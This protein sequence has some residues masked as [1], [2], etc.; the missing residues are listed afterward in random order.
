MVR[1]SRRSSAMVVK[2]EIEEQ[3]TPIYGSAK[4]MVG[5]RQ[6]DEDQSAPAR[7]DVVAMNA[8]ILVRI[9]S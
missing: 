8:T 5:R 6:G 9:F 3:Q 4:S 2:K 7:P 1:L